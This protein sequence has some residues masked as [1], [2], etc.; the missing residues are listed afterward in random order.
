MTRQSQFPCYDYLD[1]PLSALTE[2][3][4]HLVVTMRIWARGAMAR[5]CPLRLIA[6]RFLL[7]GQGHLMVPFH[8]FMMALGH[9][10]ARAIGLSVHEDGCVTDDEA[11]VLAALGNVIYADAAGARCALAPIVAA[12]CLDALICRIVSILPIVAPQ[13]VH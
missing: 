11:L 2:N 8:N 10:S 13:K 9:S 12:D 6:P 4:A 5:T 3:E 1:K 7:T